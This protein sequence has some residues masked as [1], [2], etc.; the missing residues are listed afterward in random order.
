M[1]IDPQQL[2]AV[3]LRPETSE[4]AD[5]TAHG[6]PAEDFAA[7]LEQQAS[8]ATA[9]DPSAK[10]SLDE[11][12]AS[13]MASGL[14]G[15]LQAGQADQASSLVNMPNPAIGVDDEVESVLDIL[16]SYMQALGDPQKTLKEI[17]PLADDLENGATRL[18][19]LASALEEGDPLKGLTSDTAVL[20]AV[21][22]LKFR[23]GDFV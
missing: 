18:D 21:E 7:I 16:E 9:T 11:T 12:S 2:Q 5:K 22:A 19:K 13:M 3:F 1:K 20:A 15:L 8:Q 14:L 6:S 23:R 17:A 10:L 4:K